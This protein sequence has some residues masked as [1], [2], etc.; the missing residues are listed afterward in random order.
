MPKG[1]GKKFAVHVTL[2]SRYLVSF[3]NA[4]L[5]PFRTSGATGART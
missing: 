2:A 5:G 4:H 1:G 3:P